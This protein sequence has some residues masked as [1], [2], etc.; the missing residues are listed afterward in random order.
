MIDLVFTFPLLT[1]VPLHGEMKKRGFLLT[2]TSDDGSTYDLPPAE[3]N[4]I[5]DVTMNDVLNR[6]KQA[7]DTVKKS[8]AVLVSEAPRRTWLGLKSA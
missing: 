6:A 1:L 3:Y 8:N 4:F 7:A 2:I 5:G